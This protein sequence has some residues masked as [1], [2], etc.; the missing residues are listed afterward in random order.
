MSNETE[1]KHEEGG[2]ARIASSVLLAEDVREKFEQYREARDEQARL[3]ARRGSAFGIAV[4]DDEIAV[5]WRKLCKPI[6]EARAFLEGREV[7]PYRF[8][9]INK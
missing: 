1:D 4:S 9:E 2:S 7:N 3:E 6:E 8:Y 5:E